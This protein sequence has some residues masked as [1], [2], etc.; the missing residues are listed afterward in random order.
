MMVRLFNNDYFR[1]FNSYL[2]ISFDILFKDV[3]WSTNILATWV[4]T[5]ILEKMVDTDFK[6]IVTMLTACHYSIILS[7]PV[8]AQ[9]IWIYN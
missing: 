1:L 6:S 3:H 8:L 5:D 9:H 4:K 7:D 2:P